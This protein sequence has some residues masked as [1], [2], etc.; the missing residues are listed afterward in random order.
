MW[1]AQ[2]LICYLANLA[3]D[4][5]KW[6][7]HGTLAPQVL[8]RVSEELRDVAKALDTGAPISPMPGIPVPPRT[9]KQCG[10]GAR[11]TTRTTSRSDRAPSGGCPLGAWHRAMA[12][13]EL[14]TSS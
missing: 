12:A 8:A 7:V 5:Q 3:D 4:L 9:T 6:L 13:I 14:L 1:Q 2:D 11:S 10:S